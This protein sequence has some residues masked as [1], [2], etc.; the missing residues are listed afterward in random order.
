MQILPAINLF[1]HCEL[2]SICFNLF[3]EFHDEK[4]IKQRAPW[5]HNVNVEVMSGTFE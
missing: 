5:L 2:M 3:L 4:A 1:A